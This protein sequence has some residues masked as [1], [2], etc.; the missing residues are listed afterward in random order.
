MNLSKITKKI[1]LI[2]VSSIFFVNAMVMPFTVAKAQEEEP[3]TWYNQSPIDWYVKVSDP[4]NPSEIFGERYTSAQ[5]QWI[6]YGLMFLP[7][8]TMARSHPDAWNCL[9]SM[10]S[11]DVG[12]AITCLPSVSDLIN[13]AI[14]LLKNVSGTAQNPSQSVLTERLHP[15]SFSGVGYIYNTSKRLSII[16]TV[17]AQGF[18]YGALN[19]IQEYWKGARDIAFALIVLVTIVFSFMIM[20]R[21]KL[22]PQ[23]VISVQSALPKIVVALILVS[24]SYAISG[25]MIDLMYLAGGIIA[26]LIKTAGFSTNEV[27][28]IYTYIIP[29]MSNTGGLWIFFYMVGY[30]ILF[31]VAALLNFISLAVAGAG[32]LLLGTILTIIMIVMLLWCLLLVFWYAIKI[33]WVLIKNLI[34]IY[35]SIV[36]SPLQ[37]LAGAVSP[38][39]GFGPWFKK[40][41]AELLVYPLT[42]AAF[43]ISWKFLLQSMSFALKGLSNFGGILDII[44]NTM[45]F[46]GY[47]DLFNT[48]WVP[49]IIGTGDVIAG[50][51]FLI[52]SFGIVVGIPKLPDLLKSIILG[53]K[54]DYGSAI[55]EATQPITG[56]LRLSSAVGGLGKEISTGWGFL[57]SKSDQKINLSTSGGGQ[58]GKQWYEE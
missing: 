20:F 37:F 40:L 9:M 14:D 42:G 10:T 6:L 45:S 43:Y 32:N 22:N 18:G 52:A 51:L 41:L 13:E 31:L 1:S 38:Q 48:F 27:V 34:S 44:N 7:L 49:S 15:D 33:P 53:A 4:E 26:L 58:N 56:A 54:F 16:P 25:F 47:G 3:S 28:D 36:F 21:I 19:P 50:F 5:V 23:T 55:G 30:F 57:K 24:F 11:G 12:E 35:V 29:Q 8:N 46:F 39:A 17:N 2:F